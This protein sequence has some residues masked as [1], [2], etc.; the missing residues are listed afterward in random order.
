M[1]ERAQTLMD[2]IKRAGDEHMLHL[3]GAIISAIVSLLV[4]VVGVL[5]AYSGYKISS[6]MDRAWFGLL[7]AAIG[8]ASVSLWVLTLVLW[9]FG[10][11][12]VA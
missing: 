9:Q 5:A 1:T 10:Y 12:T 6:V 11:I 7:F 8:L 4:P 2:D 3:W